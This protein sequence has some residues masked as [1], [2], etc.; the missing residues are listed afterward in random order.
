[1]AKKVISTFKARIVKNQTKG[2]AWLA[3]VT[4]NDDGIETSYD[5]YSAAWANA[6]AAK[7]WLK[8]VV[9]TT[10]PRKSIKM[11]AGPELDAKEKP[12]NFSGEVSFKRD[13]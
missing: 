1:M 9:Q 6:S 11:V 10:T 7:R 5:S 3:T 2:G 4:L 13:V 8:E 12:V